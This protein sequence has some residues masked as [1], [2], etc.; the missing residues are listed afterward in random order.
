M[1]DKLRLRKLNE[2]SRLKI[3]N[4]AA[5]KFISL[6]HRDTEEAAF[7]NLVAQWAK[8]HKKFIAPK[9]KTFDAFGFGRTVTKLDLAWK[10]KAPA[11]VRSFTVGETTVDRL[12][13]V[14]I[15]H[16]REIEV[17]KFWA[18]RDAVRAGSSDFEKCELPSRGDV[19]IEPCRVPGYRDA[20]DISF[21][22][23]FKSEAARSSNI[24]V[25]YVEQTWLTPALFDAFIACYVT[26]ER[27]VKEEERLLGAVIKMVAASETFGDIEAFFPEV[28]EIVDDL[29]P[30]APAVNYALVAISDEDKA[31]LCN[32]MAARGV[33]GALM[34]SIAA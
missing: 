5:T 31:A 26:S 4:F 29:Y 2:R 30:S 24:E 13:L 28:V 19:E 1:T 27:R 18:W 7:K 6:A 20:H 15:R 17:H 21:P 11:G 12:S 23:E 34:C 33:A 8:F 10:I 25:S 16:P 3:V 14:A 32:N 22:S 9:M